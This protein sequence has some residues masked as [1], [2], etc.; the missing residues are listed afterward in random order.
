M[1]RVPEDRVHVTRLGVADHFLN[2]VAPG[3]RLCSNP[4]FLSVTTHPKRKNIHGAMR[5]FGLVAAQYPTLMYV[6][7]G[8]ID[9]QHKRELLRIAHQTGIADRIVFFGYAS[10]DDLTDLY[11]HAVSLVYPSFYEG[12]GLPVLEAM[13]CGCPVIC[14]NI[15]SLP[16]IMPDRRWLANPTDDQDIAA[17]MTRIL[18]LTPDE[19]TVMIRTNVDRARQYTWEVTTRETMRVFRIACQR[20]DQRIAGP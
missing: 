11:S 9:E 10:T 17:T 16:E 7:S 1:F 3:T 5:A 20:R 15:S 6:L 12:F 2:G 8:V 18:A 14:S 13:A 19:R 4:Y